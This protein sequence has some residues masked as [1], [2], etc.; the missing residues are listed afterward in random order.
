MSNLFE[1]GPADLQ[2]I[3]KFLSMYFRYFVI[4]SPGKWGVA[5]HFNKP[6]DALFEISPFFVNVFLLVRNYFPLE[7][8]VVLQLNR[9]SFPSL[10]DA[11]C[12]GSL[13]LAGKH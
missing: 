12:K 6:K 1:T 8:G 2:K 5:L 9:L 7:K 13:K 4:I 3:L 11:S 10:K